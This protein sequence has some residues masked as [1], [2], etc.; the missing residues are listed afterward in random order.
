MLKISE[1]SK[2]SCFQCPDRG[3]DYRRGRHPFPGKAGQTEGHGHR[4]DFGCSC[5]V[6][7]LTG[8]LEQ[9]GS[10]FLLTVL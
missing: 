9:I 1:F 4:A 2:L 7:Y 5:I 3:H 8:L 10:L 6:E